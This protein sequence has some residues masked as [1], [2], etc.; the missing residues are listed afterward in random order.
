MKLLIPNLVLPQKLVTI[1]K[2]EYD[3]LNF[4]KSYIK[5]QYQ[6]KTYL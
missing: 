2:P 6:F 5:R 3:T 1:L 4:S